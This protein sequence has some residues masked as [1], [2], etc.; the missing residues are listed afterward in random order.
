MDR[1]DRTRGDELWRKRQA[2]RPRGRFVTADE[3]HQ[4]RCPHCGVRLWDIVHE[5]TG[6]QASCLGCG[7]TLQDS[8][9]LPL[10]IYHES[11]RGGKYEG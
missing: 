5:L 2:S 8:R 11:H 6:W 3:L 7:F 9:P 4:M 10:L 1:H